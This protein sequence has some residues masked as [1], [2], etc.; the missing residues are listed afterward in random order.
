MT[1]LPSERVARSCSLGPPNAQ[2]EGGHVSVLLGSPKP[3][4]YAGS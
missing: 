3:G 4:V 1:V 2:I